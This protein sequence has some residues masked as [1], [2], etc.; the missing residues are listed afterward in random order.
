MQWAQFERDHGMERLLEL[1]PDAA[2]IERG[3]LLPELYSQ[4]LRE[5]NFCRR[6]YSFDQALMLCSGSLA[7]LRKLTNRRVPISLRW[8]PL[9]PTMRLEYAMSGA[10]KP[11]PARLIMD[12]KPCLDDDYDDKKIISVR[13]EMMATAKTDLL[14]AWRH[15]N[16]RLHKHG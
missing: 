3:V 4:A 1:F 15:K 8:L 11:T 6:H 13:I 9:L 14:T 10:I 16:A 12:N 5:K 2:D 7:A